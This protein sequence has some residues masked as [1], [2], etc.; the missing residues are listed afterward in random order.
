MAFRLQFGGKHQPD[1]YYADVLALVRKLQP[2]HTLRSLSEALNNTNIT[3][4][5]GLSWNKTRL[6]NF[7]RSSTHNNSLKGANNGT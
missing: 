4:A 3:T 7:I 6:A 5:T 1:T 2:E